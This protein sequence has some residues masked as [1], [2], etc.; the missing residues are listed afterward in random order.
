MSEDDF[1]SRL[2]GYF[3][4]NESSHLLAHLAEHPD[5]TSNWLSVFFEEDPA[6]EFPVI[7]SPAKLSTLKEQL[8]R[9][10]ES[11][12]DNICLNYLSGVIRLTTDDFDDADGERRMAASLERLKHQGGQQVE[13]LILQTLELK[14]L[15][16]VDAQCRFARLI[17]ER[18]PESPFL[19]LI[20]S[21]FEDPYS[22]S[23]LLT[24]LL[25]RLDKLT[26]TYKGIDW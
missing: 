12:K 18:F 22:Y 25:S 23:Q 3:K 26:T 24:P 4:F 11:Y 6:S 7:I 15:F 10:L 9:F 14:Q 16:S 17:H 1:K 8:S 2:E 21:R 13:P 19:G 20:N 5:D